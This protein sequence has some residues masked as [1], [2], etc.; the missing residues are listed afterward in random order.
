MNMRNKKDK[1]IPEE[2]LREAN[3]IVDDFEIFTSGIRVLQLIQRKSDRGGS[4]NTKL[5]SIITT[6]TNEFVN[7]LASLI[8]TKNRSTT[9]LRIYSAANDRIFHKAVRHFKYQQLDAEYGDA[10]AITK[11]YYNV[12]NKF[13]SAL[14][15]PSNKATSYFLLDLDQ[16]DNNDVLEKLSCLNIDIIK[17]YKTKQGWHLITKPFNPVLFEST[18]CSIHKDGML[19]LSY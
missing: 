1:V 13:V 9:P 12:H 8:E 14:M 18:N 16:N 17:M 4:N 7:A 6:N 11:F 10:D 19:L 15:Q 2:A 3:A 5:K